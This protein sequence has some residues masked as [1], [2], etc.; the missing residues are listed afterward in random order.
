MIRRSADSNEQFRKANGEV[1]NGIGRRMQE[2]SS[3]LPETS[4]GD[5][6]RERRVRMACDVIA[7][8]VY[9]QDRDT[10]R[11][12]E[13]FLTDPERISAYIIN[14]TVTA[15][16]EYGYRKPFPIMTK[17]HLTRSKQF[18]KAW[19]RATHATDMPYLLSKFGDADREVLNM[20][21]AVI[22]GGDEVGEYICANTGLVY[23]MMV[24][25]GIDA[26]PELIEL[27]DSMESTP[28]VLAGGA[29]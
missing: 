15:L 6:Q 27:V 20:R 29:L 5:Q 25:R 7:H 26:V 19:L 13:K 24:E 22:I 28:L 2:W 21:A 1:L 17:K 10:L 3:S 9:E 14:V 16:R 11:A 8:A 12:L 4:D 23:R 18:D